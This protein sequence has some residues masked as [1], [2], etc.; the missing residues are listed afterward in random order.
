M[1]FILF[2][3][4]SLT[5]NL[6]HHFDE[7]IELAENG[8]WCSLVTS[9]LPYIWQPRNACDKSKRKREMAYKKQ[10]IVIKVE[11]LHKWEVCF[12]FDGKSKIVSSGSL[13]FFWMIPI[14]HWMRK[15]RVAIIQQYQL[16][17]LLILETE[18]RTLQRLQNAAVCILIVLQKQTKV[19]R[20]AD[21]KN[22]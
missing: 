11:G 6:L 2:Y 16:D 4:H 7:R 22:R 17:L 1:T 9:W 14:Y 3:F 18:S 10:S 20:S 15:E 12:D 21:G 13:N 19:E 8:G 5:H